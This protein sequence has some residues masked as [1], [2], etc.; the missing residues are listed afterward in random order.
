V[1][2]PAALEPRFG[3]GTTKRSVEPMR[4]GI[5]EV[6]T[7]HDGSSA[8]GSESNVVIVQSRYRCDVIFI[9]A[10][11]IGAFSL[12][13]LRLCASLPPASSHAAALRRDP[14]INDLA[15]RRRNMHAPSPR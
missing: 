6:P 10:P 13:A 5:T 11:L 8:D 14:L 7:F 12:N 2:L 3:V 9:N 15:S 1:R 4:S